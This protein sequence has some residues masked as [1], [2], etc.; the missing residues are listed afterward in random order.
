MLMGRS[1][2]SRVKISALVHFTKLGYTYMSIIFKGIRINTLLETELCVPS[3]SVILKFED[4]IA[5]TFLLKLKNYEEIQKLSNL[6]DWLLP[7]LM[8]GQATIED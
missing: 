7:M 6:R 2:D 5:S 3:L 1:E 8:N 4:C